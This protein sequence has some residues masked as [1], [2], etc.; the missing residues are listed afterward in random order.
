MVGCLFREGDTMSPGVVWS[1]VE[2][3]RGARL[4]ETAADDLEYF[5]QGSPHVR[6]AVGLRAQA[7]RACAQNLRERV[8]RRW[9]KEAKLGKI[10][11]ASGGPDLLHFRV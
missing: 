3:M 10:V 4:L 5:N 2:V 7:M 6:Q 11:E 8:K 1:R 9:G